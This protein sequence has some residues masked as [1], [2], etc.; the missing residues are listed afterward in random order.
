MRVRSIRHRV[1]E[2]HE[3]NSR[4][5]RTFSTNELEAYSPLTME[6]RNSA[7]A[8]ALKPRAPTADM[9]LRQ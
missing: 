9:K 4:R 6:H 3:Y 5:R 8:S 7:A 2:K 1:N